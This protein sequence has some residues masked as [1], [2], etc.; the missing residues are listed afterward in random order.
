MTQ[1]GPT[2]PIHDPPSTPTLPERTPSIEDA[3]IPAIDPPSNPDTP[4]LPGEA[5]TRT[6]G[7]TVP[8]P[9]PI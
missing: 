3:P 1:P 9:V 8:S 6:P 4:G 5:P 7:I 2:S